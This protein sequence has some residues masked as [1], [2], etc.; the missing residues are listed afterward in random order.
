MNFFKKYWTFLFGLFLTA[1]LLWPLFTA[2]FFSHHDDVQVIRLHQMDKCFKDL[3]IPCRWVPDLGG[4]Y[5]YPIFNYYA[6]L[7]Y[8]FGEIVY[9]L[10]GSLLISVKVMFALSFLGSFIFMYLLARRFWGEIGGSFSAIF[11]SFAPY[12]AVDFYIRGAMGEMWGLLFF[13]ALLWA[14]FRLHDKPKI[15]NLL[16]TSIFVAA[17][18]TSHNLSAF[19][20]LPVVLI[21]I[22]I[23]FFKDRQ[24]KFIWFAMASVI[25]GLFLSAFYTLPMIFEKNLVHVDS[26]TSG[27][28]Y[29]T[30]HFKGIKRL[31]LDQRWGYGSS[32]REVPGGERDNI[33]FQIG[34]AHL[35]G[36]LLSLFSLKFL[37]KTNRQTALLIIFSS[38]VI[39]LSIYMI[40]PRSVSIWK[41]IEPLKFL[42]FPWRLLMLIILFISFVS[43]SIF[44]YLK[45]SRAKLWVFFSLIGTVVLLNFSYFRPEK[46][47]Q[48]SE[49]ELLTGK[50][51]DRQIKRSILD[52]LPKSAKE[53]PAEL[54]DKRYEIVTG[55]AKVYDFKEGSNWIS[56]K[57][58]TSG[59]TIIKLSQYYFPDWKIRVNNEE[60][61]FNYKNNHLGLMNFILGKGSYQIEARLYNTPIRTMANF[62]T[63]L[64]AVMIAGLALSQIRLFRRWFF[65]YLRAIR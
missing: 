15:I 42:Q 47:I 14:V 17:L 16:L 34:T 63:I 22:I 11:Y 58:E 53:P 6:P 30:E 1:T 28:F 50:N 60:I 32:V 52:Y 35:I 26:T 23:L 54:A 55:E 62:L 37:W 9:L 18:I 7:P 3:Q 27:Y 25:L 24:I 43:G 45:S 49:K 12:H 59:H 29:F 48:I 5:G 2:P 8:Y 36:W 4:M 19:I 39:L 46:F 44:L 40:N 41:M 13:P 20:F 56:F 31:I 51:W 10:T 65:Y 61:K 57:M 33:S 38:I 21:L 64:G